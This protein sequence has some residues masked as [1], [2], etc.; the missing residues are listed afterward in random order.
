MVNVRF[1][2]NGDIVTAK[3]EPGDNIMQV[4]VRQQ[5]PRIEGECGGEL[6]C[7]TCHVYADAQGFR[8][9]SEEESELLELVDERADNSRLSCQLVLR[10]D[11]TDIEVI[12]P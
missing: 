9:L 6:S 12:I 11:M 10:E 8:P 5:L 7:A 2:V 1:N 3:G 4:A